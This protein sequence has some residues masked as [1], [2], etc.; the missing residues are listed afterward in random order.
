[1]KV[2]FDLFFFS[3]FKLIGCL[4]FERGYFGETNRFLISGYVCC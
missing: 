2:V 4:F 3:R 1:M